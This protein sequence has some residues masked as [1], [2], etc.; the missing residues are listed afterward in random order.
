MNTETT[1]LQRPISAQPH[2]AIG[3]PVRTDLRAGLVIQI[4]VPDNATVQTVA[5]TTTAAVAP[6]A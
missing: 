6:T 4:E 2:G 1:D 3:L 5:E